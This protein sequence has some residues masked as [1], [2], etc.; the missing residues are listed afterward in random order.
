VKREPVSASSALR[1]SISPLMRQIRKFSALSACVEVLPEELSGLAAPYDIRQ[2]PSRHGTG[3]EPSVST[4]Y[5][6]VASATVEAVLE[7][8]GRK[9]VGRINERL[10]QPVVEEL[11]FEKAAPQKIARQLNILALTPD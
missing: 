3:N 1:G 2:T 6:Y 9:L 4:M 10:N 5:I 7:K 11:R 8:Q